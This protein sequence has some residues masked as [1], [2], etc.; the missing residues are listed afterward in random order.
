MQ[1]A[2]VQVGING[3]WA[4]FEVRKCHGLFAN[5][6]QWKSLPLPSHKPRMHKM[7]LWMHYNNLISPTDIFI[8]CKLSAL[9][10]LQV[11]P[12]LFF[13]IYIFGPFY[14]L[15]DRTVWEQT[16]KYWVK[17]REQDRQRTSRWELNLGR[18]ERRGT[19][20]RHTNHEAIGAD[21]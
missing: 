13:F 9:T 6:C 3:F 17:R 18:R 14:P 4:C 5:S 20:C 7:T 15:F 16:G 19:V 21:M 2:C 8:S 12:S 10:L 11:C 1:F